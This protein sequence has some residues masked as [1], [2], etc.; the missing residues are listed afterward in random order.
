MQPESLSRSE[1]VTDAV[2][3]AADEARR[4]GHRRVGSEHLLLGVLAEPAGAGKAVLEALR[5]EWAAVR[6][7]IQ[8]LMPGSGRPIEGDLPL[9]DSAAGAL[10]QAEAAARRFGASVVDTDHLL[11]GIARQHEGIGSRVLTDFGATAEKIRLLVERETAERRA[12]ACS[13][14]GAALEATWRYCPFCGTAR[15]SA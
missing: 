3:R 10:R 5:L 7:E 1:A 9:T 12:Q 8:G 13:Q 2:E 4:L 6:T 15:V 14:C 11:L